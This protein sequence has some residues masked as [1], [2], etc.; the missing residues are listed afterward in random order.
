MHFKTSG[1]SYFLAMYGPVIEG[2]LVSL[3]PP[4]PEDAAVMIT[5]F[6]DLEITRF[7]LLRFPP[8]IGQEIEW[9]DRMAKSPDDIFW[10]VEKDG[11]AVGA[12]A[13]H[14]ID[15]KNGSGKTGTTIGDRSLW[16]KGIGREV[17]RLRCSFAFTQLPLRKLKSAYFDGNEAS[18]RAQAAAGYREVGRYRA[19][20]FI[21]GQWV[22]QV[23]TE[24][25]REDWQKSQGA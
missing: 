9:L 16:G 6:E 18:A 21:D 1:I 12:T 25:L 14:E 11:R 17:M 3:R 15:W 19:D 2:K 20:Q 4:K 5:W 23:V 13:I 7:I 8:S 24:V 22:D 10:V